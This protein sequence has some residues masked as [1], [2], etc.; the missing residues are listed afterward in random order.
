MIIG[1]EGNPHAPSCI[2]PEESSEIIEAQR[3]VVEVD[4]EIAILVIV[5]EASQDLAPRNPLGA[6]F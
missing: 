3:L 5:D 6:L 1:S 4:D 2:G